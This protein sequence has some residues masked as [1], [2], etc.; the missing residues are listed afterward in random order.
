MEYEA[1]DGDG[2]YWVLGLRE[3]CTKSSGDTLDTLKQLLS[4]IDEVSKNTDSI[5]TKL[6]MQHVVA[7]MSDRA[8]TKTNFNT[9]LEEFRQETLPFINQT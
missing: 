9:L 6:F 4:D 1:T 8:A 5:S 7:T 2:N 3:I